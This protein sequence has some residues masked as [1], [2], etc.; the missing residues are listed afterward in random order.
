MLIGKREKISE[1]KV[2]MLEIISIIV[3]VAFAILS[4]IF[5]TFILKKDSRNISVYV[6][7]KRITQVNGHKIDINV[8]G[9]YVIGDKSG[10]YN[11]IEIKDKKVSCIEA[12]CPDEICV[13]HGDLRK[14][15]DNDMIICAPHKMTIQYE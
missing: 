2:K 6:D 12:N 10:D 1:K 13:K 8:N 11:V 5:S 4:Y 9:T 15:I 7:G 3:I 14:D